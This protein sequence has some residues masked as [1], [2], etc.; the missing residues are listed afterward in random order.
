MSRLH[1][2]VVGT[3]VPAVFVHGSFDWGAETFP[4]QRALGEGHRVIVVDR[5]GYGGSRSLQ[6]E[7]W[8]ADMHDLA[9]LL[10]ELGPAHLVG[11]SYG[12]VVV[13]LAARLRPER[14]LSLVA[15]EPPAFEA[16][17]GDRWADATTA[18]M[19]PVF[20]GAPEMS[21]EAFLRA[22]GR[23][24]GLSEERIAAWAAELDAMGDRGWAA[25]EAARRELWPGDPTFAFDVLADARFPK[26]LVRGAWKPELAGYSDGG[27]DLAAVCEAIAERIGAR[28]VVFEDSTHNPQRQEPD[29]FNELLL[30]LWSSA[31]GEH[32]APS[33]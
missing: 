17:R 32:T 21:A 5:R 18:A 25:V 4:Y 8:P 23:A 19:K 9:E 26:L 14:V 3:G 2:E 12:A 13:L 15:I 29:A 16:A 24:R 28:I 1:S 11:Q 30:E 27:K 20:D 33:R 31:E 6:G 22:W 7:G 10:D